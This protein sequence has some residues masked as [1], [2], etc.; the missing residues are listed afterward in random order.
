M[1]ACQEPLDH[2]IDVPEPQLSV[3]ANVAVGKAVEVRLSSTQP[4]FNTQPAG[5]VTNASVKLFEN[6]Q[7]VEHLSFVPNGL[8]M[9]SVY[10]SEILPQVGAAYQLEIS[11]PD[12][13]PVFASTSIPEAV[14]VSLAVNSVH[15]MDGRD[16]SMNRVFY[17]V[18]IDYEDP[19]NAPN[20]YQLNF[21]Q[22]FIEFD[23]INKDTSVTGIS[24]EPLIFSSLG[25]NNSFLPAVTGGLL[26]EDKPFGG[27]LA[28]D[29]TI[30]ID[31][32]DQ[33]LGRLIAELHTVSKE[34]YDY[35]ASVS[36]Q[37]NSGS[38]GLSTPVFIISNIDNGVG[39]FAGFSTSRAEAQVSHE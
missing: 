18:A 19:T 2:N 34:Y 6:G 26:I 28:F 8:T 35:Y 32:K 30:E 36:R 24:T 1:T 15:E 4:I 27:S 31:R 13:E 37:Q 10:I 12:F 16:N 14:P 20:F 21:Y 9:D 7:F 33:K 23:V 29:L 25:D 39:V 11:A 3:S 38:G 5:V 17:E 22:E